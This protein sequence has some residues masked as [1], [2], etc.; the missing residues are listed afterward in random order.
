MQLPLLVPLLGNVI[1]IDDHL[2]MWVVGFG[3][4]SIVGFVKELL[5]IRTKLQ[6]LEQNSEN[7]KERLQKIDSYHLESFIARFES[8][9][10]KTEKQLD[11]IKELFKILMEKIK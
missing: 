9:E 8:F 1:E 10:Q 5:T 7:Q 4:A 11:E 3:S 2:L 6:R